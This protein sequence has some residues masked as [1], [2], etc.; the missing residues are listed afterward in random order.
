MFSTL[1]LTGLP[2][3]FSIIKN[4]T[5]PPSKAGNGKILMNPTLIERKA[6]K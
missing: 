3:I 4:N 2:L 5:L 1:E 6:T